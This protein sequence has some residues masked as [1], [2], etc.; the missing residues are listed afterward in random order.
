MRKMQCT[1]WLDYFKNSWAMFVGTLRQEEGFRSQ[2]SADPIFDLI[3][4]PPPVGHAESR[5]SASG[6]EDRIESRDRLGCSKSLIARA[7]RRTLRVL[8]KTKA[9]GKGGE[10]GFK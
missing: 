9:K 4:L 2:N 3:D 8:C 10:L 7:Y 1:N 5:S 6:I